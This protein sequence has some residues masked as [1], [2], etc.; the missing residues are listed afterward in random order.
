MDKVG[1]AAC[2]RSGG[3]AW[4]KGILR[5][6]YLGP[7]NTFFAL[8]CLRSLGLSLKTI[9]LNVLLMSLVGYCLAMRAALILSRA[10]AKVRGSL[11]A[12]NIWIASPKI[13]S[14]MAW[15]G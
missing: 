15:G 8:F 2:T 1:K 6:A 12:L 10:M 9:L 7:G 11:L 4:Q 14:L 5:S 3:F 13:R